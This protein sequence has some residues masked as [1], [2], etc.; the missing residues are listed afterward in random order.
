MAQQKIVQQKRMEAI[1]LLIEMAKSKEIVDLDSNPVVIHALWSLHGLGQLDGSNAEALKVAQEALK[2][3]S[4]AIRK[5]AVRVLPPT[6]ESTKLLTEM[7]NERDPNTLRHILLT[8]SIMPPSSET[9]GSRQLIVCNHQKY[10]RED[11]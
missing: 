6:E 8:L 2:H 11:V 4:A 3:R 7:L 5:N 9:G 10:V 1:P